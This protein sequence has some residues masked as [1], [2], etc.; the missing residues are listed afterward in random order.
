MQ[1][2]RPKAAANGLRRFGC[3]DY[4]G[5]RSTILGPRARFPNTHYATFDSRSTDRPT[6]RTHTPTHCDRTQNNRKKIATSCGNNFWGTGATRGATLTGNLLIDECWPNCK[7]ESIG[8][9]SC[10]GVVSSSSGTRQGFAIVHTNK[11]RAAPTT[12]MVRWCFSRC[13]RREDSLCVRAKPTTTNQH[14]VSSSIHTHT[15]FIHT[16]AQYHYELCNVLTVNVCSFSLS[17]HLHHLAARR[18]I[19][20]V[21]R[22]IDT[23][24]FSLSLSIRNSQNRDINWIK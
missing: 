6:D 18:N 3:V 14:G 15:N 5:I 20:Q 4:M 2:C 19:F 17:A 11:S 1:K 9:D 24:T 10:G 16:P 21:R 12:V 22:R 8:G 13:V 7:D 23:Q